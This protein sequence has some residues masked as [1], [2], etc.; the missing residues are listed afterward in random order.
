MPSSPPDD[1]ADRPRPLFSAAFWIALLFGL[2]CVI[3][4]LAFAAF[5]PRLFAA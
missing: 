3:A 5:G 1:E 2:V 4:G